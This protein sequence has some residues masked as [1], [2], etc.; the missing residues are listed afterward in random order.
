[1]ESNHSTYDYLEAVGRIED[2]LKGVDASYSD[3]SSIPARSLLTFDNGFYVNVTAVFI[4]LRDSKG[5]SDRHTRPV[6]AKIYRAYISEVIA[7]L[8]GDPK[9]SEIY[10]EGDGV[11]AVFDTPYQSD[12]DG[13]FSTAARVISLVD[14]LNVKLRKRGYAEIVAGV[15]MDYGECLYIK[16]GYK[17]SGVNEVVWIGKVV[18]AAAALCKEA[19]KMF[20]A[21]LQVSPVIHQNLSEANQNLLNYNAILGSY[22]GFVCNKKMKEWVEKNG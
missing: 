8:K 5:L 7:V 10:V 2:I 12:V 13:V 11:W 1:M 15:G 16:A 4:D 17:G 22:Q 21:T 14:I 20:N 6:L 3:K 19:G 18:G 9:I